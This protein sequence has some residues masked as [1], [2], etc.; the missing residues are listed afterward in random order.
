LMEDVKG[1]METF[2]LFLSL[3]SLINFFAFRRPELPPGQ[4][5]GC[6]RIF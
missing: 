3:L 5:D 2:S 1:K 6:F 4:S